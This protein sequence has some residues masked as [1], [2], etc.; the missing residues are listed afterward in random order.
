MSDIIQQAIEANIK[1]NYKKAIRLFQ[2][3][4]DQSPEDA[5][6]YAGLAKSFLALGN[7]IKAHDAAIK[8]IAFNPDLFEPHLILS[9]IALEKKEYQI[10]EE[11]IQKALLIDP[12]SSECLSILGWITA[13]VKS[14]SEGF[15]ILKKAIEISPN[16]ANS[17]RS[18]G[19]AWA[20]RKDWK[21]AA[22]EVQVAFQL[23]P[24]WDTGLLLLIIFI[25][26]Y[27]F[28]LAT[29][30][31]GLFVLAFIIHS[32][33]PIF[34]IA[35]FWISVGLGLVKTKKTKASLIPMIIGIL[36]LLLAIIIKVSP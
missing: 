7:Y 11:D 3:A 26:R 9:K 18:L 25:S 5:D 28:L 22:K 1:R 20:A 15:E 29:L 32:A 12:N 36:T 4:I 6:A 21:Q 27:R 34:L 30:F 35:I 23:Q 31:F 2:V 17:H 14:N 10:C 19:M 8:A 13:V 24:T 16:N 33:I